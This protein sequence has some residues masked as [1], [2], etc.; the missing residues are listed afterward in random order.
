[1]FNFCTTPSA[2][3]IAHVV[4]IAVRAFMAAYGRR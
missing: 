4:G 3:R 2:E 1:L